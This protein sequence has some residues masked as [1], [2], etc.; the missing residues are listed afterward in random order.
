[1][2]KE[3]FLF[4]YG[5]LRKG[6]KH[7][8]H[9]V[10][11]RHGTSIGLGTFQGRLYDLG[12]F[13]GVVKSKDKTASVVGEVYRLERPK[14]VFAALDQYEGQAFRRTRVTIIRAAEDRLSCWIY[15]YG[16]STSGRKRI[17]SGDYLEY[18][19]FY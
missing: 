17:P 14:E 4:V 9:Q 12:T 7:P 8:M 1:M 11:A 10:L 6:F 18:R 3:T 19:K 15:L 5:T 13:P 2:A 16:R